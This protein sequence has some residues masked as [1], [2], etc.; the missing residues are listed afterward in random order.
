MSAYLSCIAA[1]ASFYRHWRNLFLTNPFMTWLGILPMGHLFNT[2]MT[3]VNDREKNSDD[4]RF[5]VID[6]WFKT[7]R[8]QPERLTLRNIHAQAMNN[9]GAGADTVA[10]GL[11]AVIYL[12]LRDPLAVERL[13]EEIRAAQEKGLCLEKIVAYADAQKLPF[14]QACIKEALRIF[15]P[16]PM[17][18]PR[19]SP[20]GG[21]T[22]GDR[23]F[24]EGTILS[25]NPWVI[26]LSPELWGSDAREFRPE[27][28]LGEDA[29]VLEKKY[30]I[31]V[32]ALPLRTPRNNKKAD[33][34][35]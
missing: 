29:A 25:I 3:A 22:I 28:W 10:C 13:R 5:V 8:E 12:L 35:V 31:P 9:V 20:A 4:G 30:F 16:V 11:Q 18:L 32:S 34:D 15:T 1:F 6:H 23:T 33:Q 14:L 7:L 26:H 24:P 17:G 19:T 2:T 27:R 21:I